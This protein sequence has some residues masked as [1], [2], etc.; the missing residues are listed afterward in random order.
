MTRLFLSISKLK[1][2]GKKR[3]EL[4]QKLGITTPYD[5]LYYFPRTYRD[6][7]N[8]TPVFE[9]PLD[10]S[11]VVR[12]TITGKQRPVFSRNGT[13]LYRLTASDED[14]TGLE[15]L[16]FNNVYA[17]QALEVG[18]TYT[19][20]GKIGGTLLDRQ[21]HAPQVHREEDHP[22]EAVYP[23]ITGLTSATTYTYA[24][25]S[26]YSNGYAG[27]ASTITITT[28]DDEEAPVMKS[29]SPASKL[30]NSDF[31]VTARATDNQK[32]A[33]I[34]FQYSVDGGET[35]TLIEEKTVSSSSASASVTVP[36]SKIEQ[37]GEIRVQAQAT[38]ASGNVSGTYAIGYIIDRQAPG[39]P[40]LNAAEYVTTTSMSVTW[41]VPEDA[42]INSFRL[43]RSTDGT[44]WAR[45]A[46]V[47]SNGY[48]VENLT[49]NTTYSY[50][51]EA[52]DKAGNVGQTSQIMT[53][54]TLQDG[55]APVMGKISPESG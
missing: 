27:T 19:M 25:C 32:V 5:L 13:Q 17:Y 49:P 40:V 21:I 9:G 43:Y 36:V 4:Y 52:V 15:I 10:A 18:R 8:P 28:S 41:T 50:Y 26:V 29:M 24:V 54:S 37:D 11:A 53:A 20:S 31:T 2:V 30:V 46:S 34:V 6:Y 38:D 14:G 1:G 12:V 48:T 39:V 51:V 3:F 47:T 55:E 35:W 16:I 23:Q 44:S 22:I 45:I 33:K 42:D 7:R